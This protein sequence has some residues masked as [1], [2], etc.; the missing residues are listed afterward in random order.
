MLVDVVSWLLMIL[1]VV[2]M[3]ITHEGQV[4]M[5]HGRSLSL[6]GPHDTIDGVGV[7]PFFDRWIH[8]PIG[9]L[10]GSWLYGYGLIWWRFF[11]WFGLV[12]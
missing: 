2:G 3:L 11:C 1:V 4:Y 7:G 9:P 6:P 8:D 10:N 5:S 12:Q